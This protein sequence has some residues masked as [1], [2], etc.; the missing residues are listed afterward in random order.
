MILEV[1]GG[2]HVG[3]GVLR[4]LRGLLEDNRHHCA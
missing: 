1:K 2:K 3:L 4:E